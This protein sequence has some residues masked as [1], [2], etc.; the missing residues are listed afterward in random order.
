MAGPSSEIRRME[1]VKFKRLLLPGQAFS[2]NID[3]NLSD[4]RHVLT[5]TLSERKTL[6]SSGRLV[7]A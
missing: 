1:A 3:K 2:M 4:S 6:F 5:F 7:L